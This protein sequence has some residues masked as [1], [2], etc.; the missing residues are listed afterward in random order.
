[1]PYAVVRDVLVDALPERLAAGD[2]RVPAASRAWPSSRSWCAR[3]R[4]SSRPST[5]LG[6]SV[7]YDAEVLGDAEAAASGRSRAGRRSSAGAQDADLELPLAHHH[8]GVGALDREPG[9]DA[10]QRVRLDDLAAGHLVAADAAVVRALR[11][12]EAVLGPAQRAAVLE[13]GVLLLDAEPRLEVGVLL[14]DLG[15]ARRG[16]WSGAA[17]CR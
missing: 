1:M 13:E 4:R 3:R 5:G 2:D 9:L 11:R 8:L 12:G 7:A 15:A 6:S 10:R 16:C 14:G 17:S